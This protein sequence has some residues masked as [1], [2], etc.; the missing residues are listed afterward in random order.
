M[1]IF[2][3]NFYSVTNFSQI[4]KEK[5]INNFDTILIRTEY[6]FKKYLIYSFKFDVAP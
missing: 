4:L 1:L 3:F 5:K 6:C 2:S